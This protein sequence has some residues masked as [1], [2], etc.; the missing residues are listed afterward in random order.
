MKQTPDN[1]RSSRSGGFD[2]LPDNEFYTGAPTEQP[3]HQDRRVSDLHKNRNTRRHQAPVGRAKQKL[4]QREMGAVMGVLRSIIIIILLAIAF[5]ML[6]EGVRLYEERVFLENQKDPDISPVM[7]SLILTEEMDIEQ[8]D[9]TAF[10]TERTSAWDEAS[11]LA[12]SAEGLIVQGHYDLAVQR[13]QDALR[14]NPTHSGVLEMLGQL[15]FK[16]GEMIKT[17][18]TYNRLISVNPDRE[19]LQEM[20]IQAFEARGDVDAVEYLARWYLERNHYDEDVQRSL[21]DSLFSQGHFVEAVK[22]YE[23]VLKDKPDDTAALKNKMAAHMEIGQYEEAVFLLGELYET[24]FQEPEYYEQLAVCYAQLEK[25][26]EA[27]QALGKAAHKFGPEMV[28]RWIV[29]PRFDPI[30]EVR[31]FD[32]FCATIGT[33]EFLEWIKT[34]DK[35]ME[36]TE[37]GFIAPQLETPESA[38]M[39]LLLQRK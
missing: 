15:Y 19:D 22:A 5:F 31:S 8:Q 6:S 7:E 32:L 39:E 11:R 28:V 4:D 3:L 29:D 24:S 9:V 18:N 25:S 35:A 33:D 30:R 21:A 38:E 12:R 13:C 17:I 23:R 1:D 20:L 27:V 37:D 34:M 14:Y 2:N 26:Q 16:K 10:M 36:G